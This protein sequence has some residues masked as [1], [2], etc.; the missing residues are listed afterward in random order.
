MEI[1]KG[2]TSMNTLWVRACA[3]YPLR[4]HTKETDFVLLFFE[5]QAK[6]IRETTSYDFPVFQQPVFLF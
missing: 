1:H 2:L 3:S 5:K 4:Y 6:Q